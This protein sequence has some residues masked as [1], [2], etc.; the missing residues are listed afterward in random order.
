MYLV[1]IVPGWFCLFLYPKS[2]L[3]IHRARDAFVI[4]YI[5]KGIFDNS[6][7]A[8]K[9]KGQGQVRESNV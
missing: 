6:I 3:I 2:I 1:G 4:S 8:F 5:Y 9:L 7:H